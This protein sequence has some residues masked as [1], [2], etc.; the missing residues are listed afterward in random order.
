MPLEGR[1]L[2]TRF[3]R[4]S[5]RKVMHLDS[6]IAVGC[7]SDIAAM[8]IVL[9]QMQALNIYSVL[10]LDSMYPSTRVAGRQAMACFTT[11]PPPPPP[12]ATVDVMMRHARRFIDEYVVCR[13]RIHPNMLRSYATLQGYSNFIYIAHSSLKGRVWHKQRQ[14]VAK[15]T[16]EPS[17]P[18]SQP[19]CWN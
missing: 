17:H 5:P 11:I 4:V 3:H 6:Y 1:G 12:P 10:C 18:S 7:R 13:L 16:R 9:H 2:Q 19:R 15:L 8:Q 14:T